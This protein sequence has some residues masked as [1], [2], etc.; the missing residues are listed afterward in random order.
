MPMSTNEFNVDDFISTLQA[1]MDDDMQ[2]TKNCTSQYC[3]GRCGWDR[4]GL[5]A[6]AKSRCVPVPSFMY[7]FAV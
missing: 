1:F 2:Q 6:L 3:I 5:K 7:V 4:F